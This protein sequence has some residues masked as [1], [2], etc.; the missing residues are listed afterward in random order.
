M[1]KQSNICKEFSKSK[2]LFL[3]NINQSQFKSQLFG[4]GQKK[5]NK[6]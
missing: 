5:I 1:L 4:F 2:K 3:E 6:G